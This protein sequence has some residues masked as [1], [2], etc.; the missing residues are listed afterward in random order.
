MVS[1]ILLIGGSG[2]IGSRLQESLDVDVIDT[3]WFNDSESGIDYSE[4]TREDY[5]KYD[6]IILL[7]GHSSVK[8]SEGNLNSCFNNNVRN[9]IDL[10]EKLDK[11]K[12]IYASSSSV[13]G[14]VGGKTVNEKYYGFEPYNQYDIS[15]HT[16]DLYAQKSNIEYY[17]LRF[18][19]VNGSSPVLRT[20]VMINAMANSA[21]KDG[22]IKLYIK[23]TM[24][25][26]LGINDLCRAI[27]SIVESNEDKRGLYNLAS[28]N[29][30]AEQ[31][32]YEVADVMGV[33][34]KE[35]EV[36]PTQ[37]KNTKSQTKAYNFSISTL[38]FRREYKFKF[39]DTVESI[40]SGLIENWSSM[41]KTDRSETI[42]YE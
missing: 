33:E 1:K 26:I 20:D 42:N 32:A 21:L 34:V 16:A 6:T 31:I 28:F 12:L 3:N 22:H 7:A 36:D 4:L 27:E 14:S 2:Y 13:Y 38:K 30:T 37:I 39:Q 25:P 5:L 24:R 41:E 19:T 18:G 8:M 17:G 15:K 40:T 10:I 9:F 23:D 35:Y 11:Q 29:K